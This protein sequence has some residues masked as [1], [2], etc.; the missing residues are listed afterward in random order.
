MPSDLRL[1]GKSTGLH[2]PT[3]T[4]GSLSLRNTHGVLR[5]PTC[6]FTHRRT[7]KNRQDDDPTAGCGTLAR[8]RSF[9]TE[10]PRRATMTDTMQNTTQTR[11][12]AWS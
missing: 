5:V 6:G 3:T 7:T 1:L 8:R 2:T 12:M 11:L 9:T 4:T 10:H